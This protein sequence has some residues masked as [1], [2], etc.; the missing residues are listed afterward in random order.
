MIDR[1]HTVPKVFE[2]RELAEVNLILVA[3]IAGEDV[4]YVAASVEEA[5]RSGEVKAIEVLIPHR[6][7]GV[8]SQLLAALEQEL[9]KQRCLVMTMLYEADN[10]STIALESLAQK[11]QWTAPQLF[12]RQYHFAVHAF[13]PPWFEQDY[14]LPA[15]FTR[16]PWSDLTEQ[17][18]RLIERQLTGG[19]FPASVYPFANDRD[20]IEPLNSLGLRHREALIGWMVTRRTDA[21]TIRYAYFYVRDDYRHLGYSI[22]LLQEAIRLQQASPIPNAVFEIREARI[23]KHWKLFIQRRLAPF[24]RKTSDIRM[25]WKDLSKESFFDM[26]QGQNARSGPSC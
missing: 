20:P 16:F 15:A 13:H 17:D 7:H 19:T 11:N 24:A 21:D 26:P 8:A 12:I 3:S 9:K 22:A 4:G 18:R 14:P 1:R 23:D 6:R 2:Q 10:P 5:T 25:V